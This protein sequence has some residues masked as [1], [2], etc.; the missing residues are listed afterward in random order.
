MW[1]SSTA[2]PAASG[3]SRSGGEARKQSRGRSRLP[4]AA[5]ASPA[6][7]GATP[8]PARGR[9]A[10]AAPRAP[11]CSAR[12]RASSR[13]REL[14]S[15]PRLRRT[16][17]ATIEP[18]S[19]RKRTSREARLA[20]Q[21]GELLG[22][23]EAA[24]RRGQVRVGGAAR[25]RL[26]DERHDAVEPER[27]ERPSSAAR[28]RDLEDREP[29][30]GPQHAAELAQR[31]LEVGEVADAEADRHRVERRRPRTAARAGRPAPTR[32]PA[33]CAAPA[34][35][36]RSE[37]SSPVTRAA[38]RAR[39]ASARSPVP[40]PAS[41]TRSPGRT[42]DAR[43][44]PPPA[45]VEAGRHDAVHRVVDR[46]D[47][48]E[49]RPHGLGRERPLSCVTSAPPRAR[50]RCSMPIWSRHARDDEVDELLDAR[51]AVVEARR[52]RQ[53]RRRRRA[54]A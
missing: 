16:W 3:G 52:E 26:P 49:H 5:S 24:H 32:P 45:D 40:Q 6:T 23:G 50:A 12:G 27:E 54:A 47:P 31:R 53:D 35:A 29:A 9:V 1:T 19:S 13:R 36:S 18:A 33:T 10:R 39:T 25:Q 20:H 34:R 22:A 38:P 15:R 11:P 43:G 21:R 4:P 8:G 44:E 48:V 30:A 37:K 51:G 17:S 42:T 28:P 41:S 46:R 14:R 7:A 2:T